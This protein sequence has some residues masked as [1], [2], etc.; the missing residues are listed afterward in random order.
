M[1]WM[2]APVS[3]YGPSLSGMNAAWTQMGVAGT[4]L[5]NLST[6]GYRAKR[7]A[8]QSTPEGGVRP[9]PVQESQAQPETNGSNVDPA[10][11]LVSLMSGSMFFKANATV[12]RAQSE[13]L[14]TT[15]DLKA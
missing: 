3:T 5:A 10:T 13:M 12:V 2:G 1:P 8:F 9:G 14:G 11:E 6:D 15:L 4:N 7:V